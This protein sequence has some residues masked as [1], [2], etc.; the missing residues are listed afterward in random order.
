LIRKLTSERRIYEETK[1]DDDLRPE[2]DPGRLLKG[3][4]RGKYAKRYRAGAKI[5]GGDAHT[6]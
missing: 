1:V 2:Y 3:A 4:A 5:G 6:N